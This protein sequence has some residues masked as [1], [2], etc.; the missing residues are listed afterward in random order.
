MAVT[1]VV[2]TQ[3]GDEGKGKVVDMLAQEADVV[4]RFNGGNNAGHT[5]ID[6]ERGKFALHLVPAGIFNS[7]TLCLVG[8]GVVVHPPTLLEEMKE[9][10][11]KGVSLKNLKISPFAHL[12]MPWHLVEDAAGEKGLKIGTTL[13]G[14]GPCYQDKAGRW[15]AIQV[16]DMLVQK[17]F[18]EV[19]EKIYALKRKELSAKYGKTGA[20]GKGRISQSGLPTLEKI[21]KQYLDARERIIK[22][23][24]DTEK[25]VKQALARKKHILLEGAQGALL[26]IDYGTYPFVTSSN[27]TSIAAC[28]LTGINPK[29]VTRIIGLVKSYPTRVGTGPFPTKLNLKDDEKLRELGKEFGATTGRPRMCGWLDLPLLKYAAEVNHLTEIALT[30][31]DILGL[32]PEIKVCVAYKGVGSEIGAREFFNLSKAKPEYKNF[33]GWG[34]LEGCRFKDELPKEALRYI[35]TIEKFVKVSIRYISI[36]AERKEIIS[37]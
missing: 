17:H 12:I 8:R 14:I 21:K 27:T 9:L 2:G 20:S 10:E 1:I 23:I 36:G 31:M 22:H 28:F 33:S 24:D 37:L 7:N 29:E 16:G 35:A 6:P 34:N 18:L 32:M 19:L 13:R 15:R 11:S 30:K 25:I 3:W 4:V 26:D 5:I